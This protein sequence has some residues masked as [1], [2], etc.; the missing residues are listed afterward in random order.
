MVGNFKKQEEF[1]GRISFGDETDCKAVPWNPCL[2]PCGFHIGTGRG[3]GSDWGKW[4]WQKYADECSDGN[5][6][7]G[8]WRDGLE[9]TDNH[10]PVA[11]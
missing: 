6:S 3:N 7:A 4:S 2:G 9:G 1:H 11:L 10:K 8:L 5:A